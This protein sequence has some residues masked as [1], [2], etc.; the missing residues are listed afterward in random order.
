M[1]VRE[2][3]YRCCHLFRPLMSPLPS[4]SV[5]VVFLALLGFSWLTVNSESAILAFD[6]HHRFSNNVR[7][8]AEV[9]SWETGDVWPEEGSI[10]YYASLVAYDRALQHRRRG[11]A[12]DDDRRTSLTFEDGNAT[13]KLNNLGL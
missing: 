2:F 9:N 4:S 11:L 6:I 3:L 12:T 1:Y 5:V 8:W 13:I 7:R 10:H